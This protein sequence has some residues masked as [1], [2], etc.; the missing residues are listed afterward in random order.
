VDDDQV[1]QYGEDEWTWVSVC[2]AFSD[3]WFRRP[4]GTEDALLDCCVD[5]GGV[6]L[7]VRIE[8]LSV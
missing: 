3:W 2:H 1:Q 8:Q 5:L 7:S 4:R 6:W